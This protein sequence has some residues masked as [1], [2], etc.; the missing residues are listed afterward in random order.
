MSQEKLLGLIIIGVLIIGGAY[1]AFNSLHQV[2]GEVTTP[3]PTSSELT[4]NSPTTTPTFN[5]LNFTNISPSQ[6]QPTNTLTPTQLPLEKNEREPLLLRNKYVG[7][8][9]GIL[10]PE[11]LVNKKAVITTKY[12]NIE[13]EIYPEAS[14]AAS[15]FMLLAANGFYDNLTFHRVE[16]GFVIQGGDPLG[17]GRGG[18]GYSFEDEPVLRQY[19]KGIVAMAN[20]GPNTNGS[21]FFIMLADHPELPPKYTIFGAVIAGQDVVEKI[22]VGD[23]IQKATIEALR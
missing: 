9:P 23:V 7:H 21:Q 22:K 18:P 17:N 14:K 4:F 16:T 2:V 20:A 5:A 6:S 11:V 3:T 13:F 15:N 19:T 10:R 8:F 1:A 12:G